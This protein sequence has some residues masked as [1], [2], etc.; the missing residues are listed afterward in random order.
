MT[1][2]KTIKQNKYIADKYDRVYVLLPKGKKAEVQAA[3]NRAA[4]T[5]DASLNGYIVQAIREKM[6]RD[7][8]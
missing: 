2:P 3:A 5:D 1:K 7:N 8:E 4:R 6:Q